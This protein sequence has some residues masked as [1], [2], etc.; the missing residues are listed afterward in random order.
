VFSDSATSVSPFN[1]QQEPNLIDPG[2]RPVPVAPEQVMGSPAERRGRAAERAIE[3]QPHV[4]D[5]ALPTPRWHLGEWPIGIKAGKSFRLCA[6]YAAVVLDNCCSFFLGPAAAVTVSPG[7][8]IAGGKARHPWEGD[9]PPGGSFRRRRRSVSWMS[10]LR[11]E[12]S[13][14]ELCRRE[15][16]VQ[17]LYY[18]WS[19][20][21]NRRARHCAAGQR[22]GPG[23]ADRS[24]AAAVRQRFQSC[25]GRVAKW[26]DVH[27]I[28][29]LRGAP[30]H[31]MTPGKIEGWHQTLKNRIL[32]ET[33]SCPVIS[34]PDRGLRRRLQPTPLAREHRQ[35]LTPAGVYF[36]SGPTILAGRERI[37]RQTITVCRL[38]HRLRAALYP[39]PGE[40][41]PPLSY[42][43]SCHNNPDGQF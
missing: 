5:K 8:S 14:A 40:P 1:R 32:L 39:Q 31:P 10:G 6:R 20:D 38:Q 23:Q 28:K 13:I 25:R 21:E 42:P 17:N 43:A 41:E 37:K 4:I 11:G 12:D 22:A 2:E 9:P 33:T 27:K 36:G 24:T 19:K 18:R 35:S 15:G 3:E 26:L 30:Y 34:R 7:A 29:H 16:I